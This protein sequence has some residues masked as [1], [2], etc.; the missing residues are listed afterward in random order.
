MDNLYN[1]YNFDEKQKIQIEKGLFEGLKV[2]WYAKPEFTW[3][4]MVQIRVVLQKEL[5][6]SWYAK[7]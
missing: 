2:S 4:Q 7:P 1:K 6:V 3:E 5:D